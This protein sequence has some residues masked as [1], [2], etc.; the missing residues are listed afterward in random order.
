MAYI[1][2]DCDPSFLRT[3]RLL[4]LL[5]VWT[6]VGHRFCVRQVDIAALDATVIVGFPGS[7]SSLWQRAGR[8]G[9]DANMDALCVVIAYPSAIDQAR[10][11][12]ISHFI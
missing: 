4:A 9:R 5:T 2:Y 7:V 10:P 6:Y 8:C 12:H 3:V 1:P 11:C